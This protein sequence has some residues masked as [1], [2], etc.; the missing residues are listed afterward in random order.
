[1]SY[2]RVCWLASVVGRQAPSVVT[3]AA[4]SAMDGRCRR[5]VLLTSRSNRTITAIGLNADRPPI[6][7]IHVG[8]GG[9]AT[10]NC[11]VAD[12][13]IASPSTQSTVISPPVSGV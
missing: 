2:I 10:K 3:P 1:M 8:P 12:S 5:A 11:D 4:S 6:S 7:Q 9:D 13:T